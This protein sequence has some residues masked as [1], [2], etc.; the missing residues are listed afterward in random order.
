MESALALILDKIP[1]WVIWF[2]PFAWLTPKVFGLRIVR[3]THGGVKFTNTI[4]WRDLGKLSS[5]AVF[6]PFVPHQ[7]ASVV[8]IKRG[9][10][11]SIS[12]FLI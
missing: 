10:V 1:D 12:C 9:S 6:P 8:E 2:I 4:N 7:E 5:W 3:R 11:F